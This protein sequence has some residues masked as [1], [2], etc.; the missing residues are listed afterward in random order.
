MRRYMMIGLVF[1]AA[2]PA[3]IVLAQTKTP[4]ARR[5]Q[6]PKFGKSDPFYADAFKEGLV[7]ERPANLGQAAAATAAAGNAATSAPAVGSSVAAASGGAWSKL[8]SPTT[9]EDS[10][11]ALKLQVDQAV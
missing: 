7:G 9:I 11:K 10:I 4:K 8:I 1:A 6:P 5:A 3:L 2:V